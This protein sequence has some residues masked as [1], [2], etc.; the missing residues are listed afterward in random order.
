[1]GR[2][3]DSASIVGTLPKE[4]GNLQNLVIL[5]LTNNPGL[6]GPIPAEIANLK[7]LQI[8]DL[9]GNNFTGN[10]PDLNALTNLQQL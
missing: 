4:I 5:T 10:I 3:L 9:H 7:S 6:T 8:L 2:T 1:M